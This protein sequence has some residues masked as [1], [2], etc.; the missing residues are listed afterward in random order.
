MVAQI[1]KIVEEV[2]LQIFE[3]T[4]GIPTNAEIVFLGA[5][6]LKVSDQ[7]W[8]FLIRLVFLLMGDQKLKGRGKW[9]SFCKSS[10]SFNLW[11]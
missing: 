8:N 3:G 9:R 6:T 1:V 4:E 10:S 2:T 7:W 5:S 11:N